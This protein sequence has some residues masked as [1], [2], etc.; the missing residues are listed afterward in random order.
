MSAAG[1]PT[2]I[3]NGPAF[4][5]L[6]DGNYIVVA[7]PGG[8]NWNSAYET[9]LLYR[10]INSGP[11]QLISVNPSSTFQ[12]NGFMADPGSILAPAT[13]P[14]SPI[15]QALVSRIVSGGGTTILTLA[16]AASVAVSGTVITHDDTAAIQAAI[17][18][19]NMAGGGTVALGPFAYLVNR[20]SYWTGTAY[21]YVKTS[22][23]PANMQGPS[24]HLYSNVSLAGAGKASTT[25]RSYSIAPSFMIGAA[26]RWTNDG[27]VPYGLC[28]NL[29]PPSD[30]L[31]PMNSAVEG[32]ATIT[33][34]TTAN[35][36]HFNAGDM[37]VYLGGSTSIDVS[38]SNSYPYH[39]TDEVIA[40]DAT[41]GKLY[42]RYPL[43]VPIPY[44]T[45]GTAA[46]VGQI[47]NLMSRD[48]T[49]SDLS[50]E[51]EVGALNLGYTIRPTIRNVSMM[52]PSW[53]SKLNFNAARDVRVES[54]DLRSDA[55]EE[56]DQGNNIFVLNS[57]FYLYAGAQQFFVSDG[58][59]EVTFLNNDFYSFASRCGIT[60]RCPAYAALTD[61]P[62]VNHFHVYDS[63]FYQADI[64][65]SAQAIS[66]GGFPSNSGLP[67]PHDTQ[68]IGNVVQ[69]AAGAAIAFNNLSGLLIANNILHQTSG[70]SVISVQSGL[71]ENN[72]VTIDHTTF[73]SSQPAVRVITATSLADP[74]TIQGNIITIGSD[75]SSA[76]CIGLIASAPMVAAPITILNN[77]CKGG[78]YVINDPSN[79]IPIALM[80]G[81]TGTNIGTALYNPANIGTCVSARG[82]CG[83]YS[84]GYI[85]IAAGATSATVATTAVAAN[86]QIQLTQ[87]S[88]AT[89]STA[90]GITCN[91]TPVQPIVSAQ[92]ET[93]SFVITVGVAPITN[94]ACFS[95]TIGQ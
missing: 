84:S 43:V 69:I 85:T 76:G 57:H 19:A 18:A 28:N 46:Q 64:A 92:T 93:T 56:F 63:R 74:T 26:I 10:S 95:F 53:T 89:A 32:A 5:S 44:G 58:S 9:W 13:P 51:G 79:Y 70:G 90:L 3:T 55:S 34:T 4:A 22:I 1:R 83:S 49:V 78:A 91:T 15:N 52:S 35:A 80:R 66:G 40:V 45:V 87:I 47:N 50:I 38:C 61:S 41:S 67:A 30:T 12:D 21:S 59:A 54:V 27:S 77:Q 25:L 72:W 7:T 17:D 39:A 88:S 24:L 37:I 31:Y 73:G 75:G 36:A 81:N 82:I 42:L 94:P 20:Q 86:S 11:Y 60:A 48:V 68:I 71:V 62:G 29:L 65:G 14:A 23:G 16:D 33:L 8:S 6:T 2:C